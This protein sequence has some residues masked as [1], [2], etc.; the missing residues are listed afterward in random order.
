MSK[1]IEYSFKKNVLKIKYSGV[2]VPF[3]WPIEKVIAFENVLVVL[4]E[5]EPGACVNENVY[6]VGRNGS[7]AWKIENRKH[8]YDDSPYTS[9]MAKDGKVKLF[10]WDG[11]ELLIDPESGI[12]ISVGYGK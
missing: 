3:N 10:N 1:P 5:P 8:V 11:D 4:V 6:G 7:I 12:V 9:I 2:D